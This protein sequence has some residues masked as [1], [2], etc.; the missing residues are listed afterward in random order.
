MRVCVRES[1]CA[2]VSFLRSLLWTVAC[3]RFIVFAA[4]RRT[5]AVLQRSYSWWHVQVK[6]E[7]MY[8]A[9]LEK[10]RSHPKLQEVLLGT[11]DKTLI[12]VSSWLCVEGVAFALIP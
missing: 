5:C 9:C 4:S 8:K 10:F 2:D 7:I 6:D 1:L 12:E 11:G 3:G